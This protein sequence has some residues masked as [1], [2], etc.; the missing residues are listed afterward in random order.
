MANCGVNIADLSDISYGCN[1]AFGGVSG[2]KIQPLAGGDAVELEFNPFDTFTSGN[3]NKTSNPDGTV[4]VEQTFVIELPKLSD[5]KMEAIKGISNPNMEFKV[6][7]LTKQGVMLTFGNKFGAFVQTVDIASGTGR[8]DKNRIQLTFTAD[9]DELA[10]V[11]DNGK[12]A[13]SA[14]AVKA[15][16]ATLISTI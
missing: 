4:S 16:A 7:I 15:D 10:P 3:E 1:T 11:T 14:I 6:M 12:T 8:R 5:D 13:Y 2:V 9:E